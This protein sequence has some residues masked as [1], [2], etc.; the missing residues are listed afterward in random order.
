MDIALL[1]KIGIIAGASAI[2]SLLTWVVI[3]WLPTLVILAGAALA[4][5]GAYLFTKYV[6]M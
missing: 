6:K 3:S 5:Y 1:K 4:G 2:G